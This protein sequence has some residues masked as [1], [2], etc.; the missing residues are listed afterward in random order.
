M[1]R[2]GYRQP[3]NWARL[4]KIA[5][6]RSGGRCAEC[7][8]EVTDKTGQVDHKMPVSQGGGHHIDNLQILCAKCHRKKTNDEIREGFRRKALVSNPMWSL[9][10]ELE[11][12]VKNG[13]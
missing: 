3:S 13:K 2:S 10:I 11:G 7:E 4:K 6:A 5:R 9:A 8:C 1:M 12:M